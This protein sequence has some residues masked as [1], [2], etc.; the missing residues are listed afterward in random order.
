MKQNLFAF[1]SQY[2]SE[3]VGKFP[4]MPLDYMR[5]RVVE[6]EGERAGLGYRLSW[7]GRKGEKERASDREREKGIPLVKCSGK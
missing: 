3:G 1:N 6:E 2:S 7:S 5:E 4:L